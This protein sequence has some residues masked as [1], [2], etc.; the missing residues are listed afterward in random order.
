MIVCSCKVVS[1]HQIKNT[2]VNGYKWKKLVR[3][4]GLA[5]ICGT[6]A[7]HSK[8]IFDKAKHVKTKMRFSSF[9]KK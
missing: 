2:A 1:D 8:S 4:T 6:C 5:T 7:R 3:E 9:A